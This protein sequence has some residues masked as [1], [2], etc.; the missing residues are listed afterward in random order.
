MLYIVK[1]GFG[2]WEEHHKETAGIFTDILFAEQYK[3]ELDNRFKTIKEAGE[4]GELTV[5]IMNS[6][7]DEQ[8][9]EWEECYDNYEKAQEYCGTSIESIEL[10]TKLL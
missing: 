7:T 6:M 10:N 4:P 5:D 8:I 3:E 2:E 1:A 9:K